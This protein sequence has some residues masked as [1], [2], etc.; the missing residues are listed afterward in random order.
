MNI[1]LVYTWVNN[2]DDKWVA[3]RVSALKSAGRSVGTRAARWDADDELLYSLRSAEKF[4]PWINKIFIIIDGKTPPKWM[5]D[6]P[7]I[8]IVDH[9]DFIPKQYLPTYSSVTIELF[10]HKSFDFF[11]CSMPFHLVCQLI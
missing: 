5:R 1:D 6:H 3:R 10:I 2:D 11:F 9:S 8:V 7:K 4:A